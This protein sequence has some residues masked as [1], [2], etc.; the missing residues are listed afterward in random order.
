MRLADR[1]ATSR[2]HGAMVTAR[3]LA[4]DRRGG[5]LV[6]TALAIPVLVVLLLGCIE[7]AQ[8]LLVHQ[9]LNRAA[10]TMADLVSQPATISAAEVDQLFDAAQH[11]LEPFDLEAHGHVIV[12]SV[13]REE[14]DPT[15]TIDWQREGGG[16][17]AAASRIGVPSGPADMPDGFEVREGE[18]LI[19]AEIFY[20][21]EPMFFSSLFHESV[22]WHHAYRRS[23]LGTLSPIN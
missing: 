21:Y 14:G 16:S 6:E 4:R 20:D 5:I 19:A 9:K 23:R 8:F 15:A 17:L 2:R 1:T 3:R 7:M 11:L 22:V 18:N 10:S 12:T 13:S